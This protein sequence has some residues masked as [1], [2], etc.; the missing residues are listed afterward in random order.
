MKRKLLLSLSLLLG[1]GA[2]N[3]QTTLGE[4]FDKAKDRI[5]ISGYGQVGYTYKDYKGGGDSESTF[6]LKRANITIG[7]QI[8]DKWTATF[9]PEF[10]GGKVLE[11]Y[12]DYTV[13]PMLKFKAGQFK[14]PFSLENRI[15]SSMIELV[16]GGSQAMR[17]YVASD[18]SDPLRNSCGGRDLGF[19]MYGDFYFGLFTYELAI[20]NGAGISVKDNN[21]DKDFVGRLTLN[22]GDNLKISGSWIVGRG[23][24]LEKFEPLGLNEGQN[25]KRNRWSVGADFKSDI[26][27]LRFEYLAGKD[28]KTRNQ[29]AYITGLYHICPKVDIVGSVDYFNKNKDISDKA[30]N[31]VGGVQYWFH[32]KCRL[33]AQY[34]FE[35]SHIRG[36]TSALLCQLQVGF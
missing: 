20:M 18:K 34:V 33:Q 12:T 17:Y 35:D 6:D 30:W 14:T 27:D 3:A 1:L 11:L 4:I 22:G 8:T 19:M 32:K 10:N 7:A 9:T 29:G 23:H 24:A 2:I 31:F 13:L 5:T 28:F 15:S 16:N 36:N 21:K 25:Y 26:L